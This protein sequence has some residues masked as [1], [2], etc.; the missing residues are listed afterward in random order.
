MNKSFTQRIEDLQAYKEKHR[1]VN[2]K[3]SDDKSLYKFCKNIRY[4][5]NNPDA[6][7]RKLTVEDM[8]SLDALGFE[9]TVFQ[10]CAQQANLPALHKPSSQGRESPPLSKHKG[11]SASKKT[12]HKRMNVPIIHKPSSNK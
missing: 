11:E 5:R 8:A 1:H 2:I 9:W 6:G 7:R 3:K 12:R 4:A 10:S